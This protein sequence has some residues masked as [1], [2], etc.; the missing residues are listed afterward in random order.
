VAGPSVAVRILGDLSGLGA[1]F[2]K[3]GAVARTAGQRA[4]QSFGRL[5]GTLNASGVLGPFGTALANVNDAMGSILENGKKIGPVA[6]GAGAGIAAA[7]GVLSA[8]GSKEQAAHQQLR[9]A[10]TAT[11]HTYDEYGAAIERAIKHQENFG[12][13]S[14]E[15]QDAIRI[16]TQATGN[17][18]TALGLMNTAADLAAAKHE[19]L[20]EAATS[21]GKVYNGNTRL[22]KEF[23]IAVTKTANLTKAVATD[24]TRATA[25]DRAYA[26]AKQK[27]ADLQTIDSAK[28]RLSVADLVHLHDAQLKVLTSEGLDVTAHKKLALAQD[29]VRKATKAHNA[30]VTELGQ[31]LKGQASAAADTFSGKI[32]AMRAKIEDAVATF[33]QKYGP[34]LQVAGMAIMAFGTIAQTGGAMAALGEGLA[35]GPILLVVAAIAALVV[36]GYVLYRNWSTI[37]G[38]IRA[39][40]AFVWD[41]IKAHWPLLLG[42]LLGPIGIAVALIIQ[43]FDAIKNVVG[44]VVGAVEHAWSALAGFFSGLLSTIG[45]YFSTAWSAV[46][47]SAARAFGAVTGIWNGLISFFTGLGGRIASVTAG[48]WHGITDAFR[49][50]LNELIDLWDRLHFKIGGWGVGPVHVPTVTVG[51]PSIPHLQAGGLITATGLVYA[52]AGEAITPAGAAGPAVHIEH[53]HFGD[54]VD[55]DLLMRRVAFETLRR[56]A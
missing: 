24:T 51:L 22:L 9:A 36:A 5:L 14:H 53:A 37:W 21:L 11:G 27:L 38:G 45:G 55:V 46:T 6:I 43:H 15:T 44:A 2:D 23:G 48:M 30:A 20:G 39:A 4:Q 52:H 50:A 31:K 41:W 7:G 33:G 32:A 25:A 56:T 17:A 47:G 12:H 42:I 35:L 8:L 40:V 13:T 3:A 16:L 1:S 18:S 34:A 28:K 26:A 19:S 10:I 29:A 49:A 54:A